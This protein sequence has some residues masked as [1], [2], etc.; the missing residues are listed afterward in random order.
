MNNKFQSAIAMQSR[1]TVRGFTLLEI[2]VAL[3][4]GLLLSIGIVSLFL[5]TSRTNKLQDGLARLQENGR[6]A[7]GRIES[8]LRMGGAQ[9]C[10]NRS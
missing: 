9:Y 5:T 8:D 1:S 4:L 7:V 3:V 10:S 6:Y 2:M